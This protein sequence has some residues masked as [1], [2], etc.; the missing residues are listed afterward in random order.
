M[1]T[2]SA[3]FLLLTLC[4]IAFAVYWVY[5][6]LGKDSKAVWVTLLATGDILLTVSASSSL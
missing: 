1:I 4:Y 2:F 3:R 5:K 6:S